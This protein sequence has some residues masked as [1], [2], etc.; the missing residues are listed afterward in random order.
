MTLKPALP[1]F[2]RYKDYNFFD[3]HYAKE[4]FDEALTAGQPMPKVM[5][6]LI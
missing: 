1:A 2:K 4:G 5:P 3:P 6:N